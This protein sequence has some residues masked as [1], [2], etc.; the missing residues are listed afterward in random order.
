M[1]IVFGALVGVLA[2]Y[3]SWFLVVVLKKKIISKILE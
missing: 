3:L 1:D 2:A